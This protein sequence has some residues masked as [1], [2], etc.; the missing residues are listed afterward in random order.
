MSHFSFFRSLSLELLQERTS[1]W[2]DM[3]GHM[4]VVMKD[5]DSFNTA[6]VWPFFKPCSL[7]LYI[8]LQIHLNKDVKHLHLAEP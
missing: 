2:L 3:C 7:F 5:L 1:S 4:R 8:L 6:V